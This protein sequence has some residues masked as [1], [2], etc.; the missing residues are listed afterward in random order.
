MSYKE[1][2]ER[3]ADLCVSGFIRLYCIT[4]EMPIDLQRLCF[5]MYLDPFDEWNIEISNKDLKFDNKEHIVTGL[6]WNM[7]ANAFGKLII[8]EGD[9]HCWQIKILNDK[10]K[11]R[12]DDIRNRI[13][14]FGIVEQNV[15]RSNMT[16]IFCW[17]KGGAGLYSFNGNKVSKEYQTQSA[18]DEYAKQWDKDDIITMTLDMSNEDDKKYGTLSFKI[19][20]T[21]YGKKIV[22]G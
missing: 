14:L 20:E 19:N 21:D 22:N 6:R 12:E 4:V 7:W 17:E 11:Q 9:I 2:K 3:L 8:K 10:K 16:E 13:L 1:E 15:A 18:G 5:F